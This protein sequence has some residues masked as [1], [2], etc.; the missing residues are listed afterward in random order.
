MKISFIWQGVSN[1]KIR[2]HWKDGLYA[3][4][5]IL[6]EDNQVEY[7]EPTDQ[8]DPESII[9][10][11]EAPCTSNGKDGMKYRRIQSLPNKKIL[12]F[13]G[14]PIKSEWAKG[15]DMFCVES[16]INEEEC[17]ALGIPWVR[18]FGVNTQIFKPMDIINIYSACFPATCA[19]WKRQGLFA[20]ALGEYGVLCGRDQAED[21]IPF[22]EARTRGTL[23]LPELPAEMVNIVYN[24]S[25]SLVNTSDFWGGGQRATL[26]S[27][28]CDVFP[29]VMTDSPKNREYIEE[30]GC[31]A[32]VEPNSSEISK[33]V[34]KYRE[35]TGRGREYI[36]RKWTE[37]HY[38]DN[39]LKAI[40]AVKEG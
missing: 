1:P 3:A 12:L 11:W 8:I 20:E 25:H 5:K 40:Y 35:L 24:V 37:Q 15:F 7:L 17:S 22:Q 26:E 6:E 30:S 27:L 2:E 34:G 16:K 36:M 4:M 29:I 18:A 14:G 9:L 19:S 10:Y 31:G 33:A 21:P 13:A 32:I 38:A 23:V 39:L 28:A